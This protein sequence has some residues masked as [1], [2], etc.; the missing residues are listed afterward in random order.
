MVGEVIT[1]LSAFKTMF[2]IAKAMK[3]MDD[4]VK[5][6]AATCRISCA[7]NGPFCGVGRPYRSS[8]D[9]GTNRSSSGIG[10][11]MKCCS[12]MYWTS[13]ASVGRLASMPY[14]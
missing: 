1:G 6:N 12:T 11:G 9:T 5:R 13:A 10:R 3:D 4:A 7:P 2:D 14:G 8:G